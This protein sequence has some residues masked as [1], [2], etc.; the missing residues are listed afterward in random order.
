M[1]V[2]WK[3]LAAAHLLSLA[4]CANASLTIDHL[5]KLVSDSGPM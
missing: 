2:A 1:T 5:P 3:N 4:T